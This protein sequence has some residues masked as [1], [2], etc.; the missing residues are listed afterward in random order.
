MA[1]IR[2]VILRG[3]RGR[4][5]DFEICGEMRVGVDICSGTRIGV[6][7]EEWMVVEI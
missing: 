6:S 7:G 2:E 5:L 1:G 4:T 3:V